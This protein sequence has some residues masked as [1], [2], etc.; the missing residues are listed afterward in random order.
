M[1]VVVSDTV[2]GGAA[3][4]CRRLVKE[5]EP[6]LPDSLQWISAMMDKDDVA[7][8]M[9]QST[10][11]IE[12]LLAHFGGRWKTRVRLLKNY[13]EWQVARRFAA[14][15]R[16]SVPDI[17][18]IHNIHEVTG[19]SF[20]MKLPSSVHLVWTLHDMWPLTGYCC[21]S[22][23]CTKFRSG[24]K[25]ECPQDGQWGVMPT[26]T[27]ALGWEKRQAI[28]NRLQGRLSFVAPSRWLSDL[29]RI[30]FSTQ[31][32]VTTIPNG[33]NLQVFRPIEDRNALRRNLGLPLDRSIILAGAHV[34]N[35][36]LKGN[37]FVINAVEKLQ[38]HYGMNVLV[39]AF[40]NIQAN[41]NI[42]GGWLFTGC[43]RDERLLNLYY[44]VA[45]VFV[46]PSLADNLPNT[47][48]EATAAGTPSVTF[49]IG[50][51]PEV[52][53]HRQTGY[54]AKYKDADDLINGIRWI[55]E[56]P[57]NNILHIRKV[58]REVAEKEYDVRL[59][60]QRYIAL[61]EKVLSN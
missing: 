61:F 60:A 7:E 57:E 32:S 31:L 45:D 51:C 44:N 24:C 37:H 6:R 20:L 34:A 55:L 39:V 28:L 27:A 15:V 18:N 1:L 23:E 43:I 22:F 54:V 47:L 13:R 41:T 42:P 17:I 8:I 29:S 36:Y 48:I 2:V 30:R 50:G 58:C 38:R 9:P 4:A 49:D 33:I 53:R 14:E 5:L 10:K 3:V 25:G 35:D 16:N 11:M 40:G 56:M 19:F 52:V 26:Q 59:M 12:F 46:H 21:C